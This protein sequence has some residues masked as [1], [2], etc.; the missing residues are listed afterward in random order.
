MALN[1]RWVKIL[2]FL[3]P[4]LIFGTDVALSQ[5]TFSNTTL[6]LAGHN[7]FITQPTPTSQLCPADGNVSY[8]DRGFTSLA[9][10]LT[11]GAAV[12]QA[13]L[14]MD[15]KVTMDDAPIIT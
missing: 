6:I 15:H 8:T 10:P 9:W 5:I 14:C 1:V 2:V 13:S 11:E 7:I 3:L 12:A 4:V